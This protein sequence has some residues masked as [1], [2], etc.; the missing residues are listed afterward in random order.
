M[1]LLFITYILIMKILNKYFIKMVSELGYDEKDVID[2][3]DKNELNHATTIYYLF[4]NDENI[5]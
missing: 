3:L 1:L 2:C 4:S 5:K